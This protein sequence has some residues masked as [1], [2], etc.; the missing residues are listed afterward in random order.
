MGHKIVKISHTRGQTIIGIPKELANKGGFGQAEYAEIWLVGKRIINIRG[1][2]QDEG[3]KGD[4]SA[5]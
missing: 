5:D 4:V 3:R 2:R 1:L